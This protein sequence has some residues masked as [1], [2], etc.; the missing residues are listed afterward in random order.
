MA[1]KQLLGEMLI[2]AGFIDEQ[3]SQECLEL[4]TSTGRRIGDIFVEKG[5]ITQKELMRVLEN[6]HKV[7]YVDLDRSDTD[8][9]LAEYVPLE[10]ARRNLL[11]PVKMER[12]VLYI[13]IEDPK[14]FR[15]LDEV[16]VAARMDVQ[17]MLA[18]A[19]SIEAYIDRIYGNEYAQR[20]LSDFRKEINYDEVVSAIAEGGADDVASAPIVRL[21]NALLEQAVGMGA[22]DIHIEPLATQVRVRMRVDGALST[23]LHT[24]LSALSAMIARVKILGNLNI[25]ERRAPQDGRFNMRILGREID[26]R[27]STMPTVHGEKAV[28]RLLDRSTFLISK[29]KLGFTEQNLAK[30][31]DLLST[32][33]GIILVTGPTGSGKST[34]L[35]TMLDEINNVRDNIVTIEDPVEYMIDGL[36]QVPVNPKAGID[37]ASGLRSILRQDPDVIMV[38]EIRDSETVDI[39]IRAAI[40]GHLVLSTIHTNDAV[41]TIYRLIDLGVPA[42]MVAASLVGIVSQRLVRVICPACKQPYTPRAEELALA[43]VDAEAANQHVFHRG[44]GCSACN[45][46]GYKGRMAVHE[47]LIFDQTFRDMVHNDASL[48]QLRKYALE[49]GMISLRDSAMELVYSGQTTLDEIISITHGT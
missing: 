27:L 14:N 29:A 25:A 34:T 36:N 24:P 37:F 19:R 2:N 41:S 38:G 16:R 28:L 30:F 18:S 6:Q 22:S 21:I 32:P 15:A 1:K 4:Q 46:T 9:T 17:P 3:Q 5:Y 33:H 12:N 35:Y 26:V 45:Q 13:A 7:P 23:V 8:P 49:T 44:F 39:A 40:T 47:I 31:N 42:Y 43:G 48:G 20:A 10:L 11:V